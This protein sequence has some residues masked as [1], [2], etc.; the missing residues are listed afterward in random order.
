MAQKIRIVAEAHDVPIVENPPL[1]RAIFAKVDL[2]EEIPP[3]HYHAI[4]E[5]IGYVM[6]LGRR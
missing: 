4:A 6:R 3:E 5:I 1:T 2:G